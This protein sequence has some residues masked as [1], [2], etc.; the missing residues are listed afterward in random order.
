AVRAEPVLRTI[1]F[2]KLTEW[3]ASR[4]ISRV[5]FARRIGLSPSA[6]TQLCNNEEAWLARETA[7]VILREK[8]GQVTPNDFMPRP[9]VADAESA[10][11]ASV[12]DVIEAFSRGEMVI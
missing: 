6:V 3:L 7:E 5:E 9:S 12:S 1:A 8:N 10:A 11:A 4:N 2:M